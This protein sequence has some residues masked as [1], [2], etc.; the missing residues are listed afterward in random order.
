MC[1]TSVQCCIRSLQ[2]LAAV[3]FAGV[4]TTVSLTL[5]SEFQRICILQIQT[6]IV[7]HRLL[8]N[9]VNIC[10]HSY[11]DSTSLLKLQILQIYSLRDSFSLQLVIVQLKIICTHTLTQ[12]WHLKFNR[13][14]NLGPN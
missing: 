4:W 12:S 8:L 6:I 7:K 11:I 9:G 10:F 1:F 13:R 5:L 3:Q 2:C 14:P